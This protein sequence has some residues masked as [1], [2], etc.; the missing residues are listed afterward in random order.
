M[1]R[2]GALYGD[3]VASLLRHAPHGVERRPSTLGDGRQHVERELPTESLLR[4]LAL[5]E[6]RLLPALLRLTRFGRGREGGLEGRGLDVLLT[7]VLG[8]GEAGLLLAGV[9]ANTLRSRR[10]ERTEHEPLRAARDCGRLNTHA[11]A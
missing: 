7:H 6:Q 3:G 8:A 1:G 11:T 2:R 10:R 5:L 9:E 4:C